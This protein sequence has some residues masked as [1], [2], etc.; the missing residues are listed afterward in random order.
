MTDIHSQEAEWAVLGGLMLDNLAIGYV[1]DAVGTHDFHSRNHRMMFDAILRLDEK[2]EPFDAVSIAAELDRMGELDNVGGLQALGNMVANT[3][4]S[5]NI[6]TYARVVR[7]KSLERQLAHAASEIMDIAHGGNMTPQEKIDKAG[8]LLLELS[9]DKSEN[10]PK[11]VRE[12][13]PAWLVELDERFNNG[14]DIVGLST[15]Y[16]DLDTKL[17]GLN[18]SDLIIVAGRPSMG[19]STFA[20]NLAENAAINGKPVAIFSLEMPTVQLINRMVSSIGRVS[21][22]SIRTGK[23][24]HDDWSRITV[25]T[26]RIQDAPIFIDDTPALSISE[27]RNRARRLKKQ[28]GIGLLVVDYIQLMKAPGSDNRTNEIGNISRGLKQI[29]KELDIP[30]VALS[31]LSRGVEQRQDRRPIMSDLRESGDIE[32]DA[33]IVIMLYRDE[34]YNEESADKGTAEILVRKQRN[35]PLGTVRLAFNGAMSRFDNLMHNYTH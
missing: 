33:D 22:E 11:R 35:G 14:G 1:L 32:Q 29:A 6:K 23:V 12:S 18:N 28:D 9:D 17:N 3:P 16:D 13:L 7:E 2:G 34:V 15:G 8:G 25:A 30:V 27:L 20:V 24:G 5:S 10:G 31:Q 19:K 21:H 26:S 4:S